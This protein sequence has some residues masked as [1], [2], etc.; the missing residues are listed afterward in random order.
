MEVKHIKDALAMSNWKI[1][2]AGG[3]AEK[4]GMH[5]KTLSSRI[6][7]LGISKPK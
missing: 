3:A 1:F 2:G 5:P 4:L 6:I 7:K